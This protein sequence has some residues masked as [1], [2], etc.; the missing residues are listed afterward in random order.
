MPVGKSGSL[1]LEAKKQE[2]STRIASENRSV[3]LHSKLAQCQLNLKYMYF[4]MLNLENIFQNISSDK[5]SSLR[6]C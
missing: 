3:P 4:K 2:M 6:A 1:V 5:E